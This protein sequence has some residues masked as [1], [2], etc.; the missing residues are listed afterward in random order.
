MQAHTSSVCLARNSNSHQNGKTPKKAKLSP[1]R[2]SVAKLC[3]R[4]SRKAIALSL[5]EV[6]QSERMVPQGA[7]WKGREKVYS[8]RKTHCAP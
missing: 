1:Y 6:A 3:G 5:Q 2:S 8:P 7:G 4:K